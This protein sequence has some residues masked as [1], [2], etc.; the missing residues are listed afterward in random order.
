VSREAQTAAA[1]AG[2]L[3]SGLASAPALNGKRKL[4]A[5]TGLLAGR[6][7]GPPPAGARWASRQSLAGASAYGELRICTS[8]ATF[9]P[10]SLK[11]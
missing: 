9:R 3:L 2:R 6:P 11:A 1:Q 5:T 7:A 10:P 8:A 4:E